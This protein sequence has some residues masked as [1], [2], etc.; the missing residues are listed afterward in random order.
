MEELQ[1]DLWNGSNAIPQRLACNQTSRHSACHEIQR[2][3]EE[4]GGAGRCCYVAGS[5]KMEKDKAGAQ[6]EDKDKEEATH[7]NENT[8]QKTLDV[9]L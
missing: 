6:G 4:S 7:C 8:N 9:A 1:A 3:T 5:K 2:A